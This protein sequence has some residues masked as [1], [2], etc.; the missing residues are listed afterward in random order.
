MGAE[1]THLGGRTIRSGEAVKR[2][3]A[4]SNT[5]CTTVRRGGVRKQIPEGQAKREQRAK[6]SK[7]DWSD[8]SPRHEHFTAAV[9]KLI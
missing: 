2:K 4:R 7:E 8:A 1:K 6:T 9:P 3:K 5:C